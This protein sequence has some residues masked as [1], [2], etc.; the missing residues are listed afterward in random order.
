[1]DPLT[2]QAL[3]TF[4]PPEMVEYIQAN[5]LH[6]RSPLQ[7]ILRKASLFAHRAV[8]AVLP[9]LNPLVDR[10]FDAINEN[11]G[12]TGLILALAVVTAVVIIMNWIR[13]VVMWWTRL[14]ARITFWAFI[15]LAVA[16][17][18]ERGFLQS[19]RD[20]VVVV[21][22]FAGYLAALKDVWISEYNHYENQRMGAGKQMPQSHR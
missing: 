12:A 4:L 17:A 18:W 19:A 3:S 15:A 10:L 6:P 7:L 14:V 1:M 20:V 21:S 11:Q 13:R 2:N 5:F 22:K 9:V 8:G 16:A